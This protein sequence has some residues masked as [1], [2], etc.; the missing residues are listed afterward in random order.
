MSKGCCKQIEGHEQLT[1]NPAGGFDWTRQAQW[2]AEGI[3]PLDWRGDVLPYA[4]SSARRTADAACLRSGGM[5]ALTYSTA[6]PR[7]WWLLHVSVDLRPRQFWYC[8]AGI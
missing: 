3:T 1:S 2:S 8:L 5:K 4:Q 7:C 6:T